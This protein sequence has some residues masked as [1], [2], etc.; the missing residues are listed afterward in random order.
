MSTL[1][2]RAQR[3]ATIAALHAD[4][5]DRDGRFPLEAVTALKAERLLGLQFP[6]QF[7]GEG[8]GLREIADLCCTLGQACSSAAMVFAMHH[9][10]V[11]SLVAHGLDS[12]WHCQLMERIAQEQLLVA[13][14]TTEAGIGGDLRTSFCAVETTGGVFALGKDA[15][16]ISYGTQADLILATARRHPEAAG[17]DQVL[18][19]LFADQVSLERK[20][21][22]DT[23]G[24]RGTCSDGFRLEARD[25]PVEQILPKPFAEIAAQSM[26]ASS[27]L[28]WSSVWFGIASSAVDRA[29]TFVQTEARR[30]P[31]QV[32]PTALRL[33]EVSNAL[34]A[35]RAAIVSALR[36]YEDAQGD[37]D[38]IGSIGFSV[39]LNNLKTT[40]S[41]MAVDI[42]QRALSIVGLAGYQNGTPFSLGRPLRDVL[43]APLMIGNDRIL[44]NTAKLLLV[45]KGGGQLMSA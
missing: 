34:Q 22:W 35:M 23:L 27:H 15:S 42:V 40:A 10:K 7:G 28:L 6:S 14:S 16:V 19:A 25:I 31:G 29:R 45:Q 44:A 21:V 32:P 11:A 20:S 13:S 9:I 8:A 4:A 18:V 3:A 30:Q 26:L 33:A 41:E 36:R 5:V 24:M 43:S 1:A 37:V 12:A 2:Q 38:T 17:S 39:M